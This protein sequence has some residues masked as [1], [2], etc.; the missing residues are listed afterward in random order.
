[1]KLFN[2]AGNGELDLLI[3]SS[4]LCGG[5]LEL[6][7]EQGACDDDDAVLLFVDEERFDASADLAYVTAVLGVIG[8]ADDSL[9]AAEEEEV[10]GFDETAEIG[11][12]TVSHDAFFLVG[13]H[14]RDASPDDDIAFA[15]G[16]DH[17]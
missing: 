12:D 8:K 9:L 11:E 1:L 17:S 14:G 15:I 10:V 4:L 3:G 2:I 6:D 5:D 16:S 13:A 7:E